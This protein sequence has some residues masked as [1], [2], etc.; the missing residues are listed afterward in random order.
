LAAWE[1]PELY[2]GTITTDL[3]MDMH[4]LF[5]RITERET[6]VKGKPNRGTVYS[7]TIKAGPTYSVDSAVD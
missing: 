5:A 6:L 4:I 1:E 2:S 3:Q 7:F